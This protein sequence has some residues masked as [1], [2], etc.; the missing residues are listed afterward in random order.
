MTTQTSVDFTHGLLKRFIKAKAN[1]EALLTTGF[2][3]DFG[4]SL[5]VFI[6]YLSTM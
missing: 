6:H 3:K 4:K 1:E 5:R 2:V